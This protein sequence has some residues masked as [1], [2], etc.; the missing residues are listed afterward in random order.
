MNRKNEETIRTNLCYAF[1]Q[2]VTGGI[3]WFAKKERV[4]ENPEPPG[5]FFRIDSANALSTQKKQLYLI[6]TID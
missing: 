6:G 3:V 1:R 5:Y 4:G 2:A